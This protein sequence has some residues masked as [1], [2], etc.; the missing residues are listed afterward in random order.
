MAHMN[1]NTP[2]EGMWVAVS[3]LQLISYLTLIKLC[4]PSNLLL[5][6]EYLQYAHDFNRWLPNPFEFLFPQEKLNMTSYVD[7]FEERGFP[8]RQMLYLCGSDLVM[9]A[10][11][12]IAILLLTWLSKF[13]GIFQKFLKNLKFGSITRSFVQAY[14]KICLAACLNIG[15]VKYFHTS[16]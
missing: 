10:A 15:I 9:M 2:I 7:Q 3:V 12:G 16:F 8:N 6:L 4:F 14:L 5:F 11:M 13:H 1:S